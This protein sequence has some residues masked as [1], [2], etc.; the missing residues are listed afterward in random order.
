M[1]SDKFTDLRSFDL[2]EFLIGN[3]VALGIV[4]LFVIWAQVSPTTLGRQSYEDGLVE[5][6]TAVF[7]GLSCLG[8]ILGARRSEFLKSR[9]GKWQYFFI[10]AWAALM[11]L[12]MGE[13]ASWGQWYFHFDTPEAVRNLNAQNEFN[14]HN[15]TQIQDGVS[16]WDTHRT[17]VHIYV[18]SRL[19]IT[20]NFTIQKG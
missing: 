19:F 12:F 10:I 13:E 7:L 14:L 18:G 20:G 6:L 8:F 2:K 15:L 3:I 11:F 1:D 17:V 16:E 9:D 5:I 4:A